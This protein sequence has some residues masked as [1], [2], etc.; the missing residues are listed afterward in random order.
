LAT[1]NYR[2]VAAIKLT[3]GCCG[4]FARTSRLSTLAGNRFASSSPESARAPVIE[5]NSLSGVMKPELSRPSQNFA[6]EQKQRQ[7]GFFHLCH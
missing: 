6:S 1:A 4:G 2:L 5:F 7:P 3:A